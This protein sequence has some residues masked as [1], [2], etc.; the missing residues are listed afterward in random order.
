MPRQKPIS[1]GGDGDDDDDDDEND[2]TRAEPKNEG[3][4]SHQAFLMP[5][6]TTVA[7]LTVIFLYQY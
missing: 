3:Y 2:D 7:S 4:A 1:D 6:M 5:L